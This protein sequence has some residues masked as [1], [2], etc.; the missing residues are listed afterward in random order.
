VAILFTGF[1]LFG[2]IFFT[3]G[4]FFS[5]ASPFSG[6]FFSLASPFSGPFFSPTSHFFHRLRTFWAIFFIDFAGAVVAFVQKSAEKELQNWSPKWDEK[7]SLF[8]T[9][10][11]SENHHFSIQKRITKSDGK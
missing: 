8:E 7:S 4:P 10:S 2:A 5:L 9:F 6:P 1:A 3:G 11:T